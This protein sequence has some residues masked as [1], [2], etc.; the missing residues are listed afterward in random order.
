MWIATGGYCGFFPFAPG[1]VGSAV[2]LL[3]A[4]LLS[5][6]PSSAG[7]LLLL[8]VCIV[9][10]W[11]A[12]RAGMIS[13]CEDPGFIVI[14][15]IAGM[16]VTLFGHPFTIGVVL[17]GFVLFRILDVL[18]PFPIGFL[19][20]RVPGG[21]GVVVDDV[22]AGIFGNGILHLAAMCHLL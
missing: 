3:P 21:A 8:I 4:F 15:E 5:L 1:T 16:M 12:D 17:A 19:E 10:V 7:W 18:K 11:A 14:D 22:A 2:A 20:A 6:L 9:S 13:G